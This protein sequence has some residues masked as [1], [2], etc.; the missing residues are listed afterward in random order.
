M[1]RTRRT[2]GAGAGGALVGGH[3]K[4]GGARIKRYCK[5]L[6]A[7][8]DISVVLIVLKIVQRDSSRFRI[9]CSALS[10]AWVVR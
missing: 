3:P 5:V 4:I 8:I 9:G 7:K 6:V 2:A 10:G 1:T